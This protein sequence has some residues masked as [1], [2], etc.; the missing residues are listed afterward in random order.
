MNSQTETRNS[1]SQLAEY[2]DPVC[3]R[4]CEQ[5]SKVTYKYFCN[6]MEDM[7]S[8]HFFKLIILL[9]GFIMMF[10]TSL[11]LLIKFRHRLHWLKTL[12]L[13]PSKQ[14]LVKIG[15]VAPFLIMLLSQICLILLAAQLQMSPLKHILVFN[16]C[17]NPFFHKVRFIIG[18]WT[19]TSVLQTWLVDFLGPEICV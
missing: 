16:F 14:R 15:T 11:F 6:R 19:S 3:G 12:V 8:Y 18:Q 17:R 7:P 5:C 10:D 4:A 13:M 9:F 1:N 2:L